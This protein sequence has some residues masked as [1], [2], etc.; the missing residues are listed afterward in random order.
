MF[1]N[2]N[3][4]AVK[5]MNLIQMVAGRKLKFILMRLQI[6]SLAELI[7]WIKEFF[8]LSRRPDFVLKDARE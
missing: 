8:I 5:L 1:G 3:H 6:F 7:I 4:T 2:A